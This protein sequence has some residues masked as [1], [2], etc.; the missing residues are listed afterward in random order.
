M[1]GSGYVG[2][3]SAVCFT[4]FVANVTCVDA[5]QAKIDKGAILFAHDPQGVEV[6]EKLLSDA[7]SYSDD[8]Y[9]ADAGCNA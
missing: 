3:V 4:E 1:I 5:D 6:A 2:S 7:V 9:K 8:I